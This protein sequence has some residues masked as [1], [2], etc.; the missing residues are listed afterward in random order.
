M[1][2]QTNVLRKIKTYFM[3]GAVAL[4]M[5]LMPVK[6]QA[7]QNLYTGKQFRYMGVIYYNSYKFT[8]YSDKVLPANNL[9]IPGMYYDEQ[10]FVCDKDGYICIASGSLKKGTVT[11]TPFGK[12]GKVYDY[13]PTKNV[14]DI[15]VHW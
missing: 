1:N 15:Y 7:A 14:I 6:V 13:C 9:G 10:N 4:M 12:D 2:Y 11:S 3:I 8:W 5:I